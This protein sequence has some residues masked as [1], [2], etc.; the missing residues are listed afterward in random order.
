LV[1]CWQEPD[2][3]AAHSELNAEP[4]TAASEPLTAPSTYVSTEDETLGDGMVSVSVPDVEAVASS[5]DTSTQLSV[6]ENDTVQSTDTP[7]PEAVFAPANVKPRLELKNDLSS[8]FK[9][10]SA[11]MKV[12]RQRQSRFTDIDA[13]ISAASESGSL[14]SDADHFMA[15]ASHIPTD[16]VSES[17]HM[18]VTSANTA[19]LSSEGVAV[20][21][22]ANIALQH[23][24]S[25][26]MPVLP[27]SIS[28]HDEASTVRMQQM[29]SNSMLL[30]STERVSTLPAFPL[31]ANVSAQNNSTTAMTYS[32]PGVIP[33][34]HGL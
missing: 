26:V 17:S 11:K 34:Q 5:A 20:S 1:G 13:T 15:E 21:G 8:M 7:K 23:L 2:S 4:T 33:S 9:S 16:A 6:A 28:S 31:A 22:S 25:H 19:P 3:K 24:L 29:T 27:L 14:S 12:K 32:V 30:T 18:I 10:L